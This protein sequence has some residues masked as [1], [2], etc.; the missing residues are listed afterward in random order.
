MGTNVQIS[1]P[2]GQTVF[3]VDSLGTQVSDM[4]WPKPKNPIRYVTGGRSPPDCPRLSSTFETFLQNT[5]EYSSPP[6]HRFFIG[7]HTS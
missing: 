6:A 7:V 4:L 5:R 2:K 1:D 3:G